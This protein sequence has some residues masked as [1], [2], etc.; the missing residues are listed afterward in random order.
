[1]PRYKVTWLEH[2]LARVEAASAWEAKRRAGASTDGWDFGMNQVRVVE[3]CPICG[4]DTTNYRHLTSKCK[5][6]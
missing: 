3:L 4:E 5:E 1:M 2:H 6:A